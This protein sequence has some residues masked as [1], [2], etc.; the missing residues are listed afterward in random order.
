LTEV[1]GLFSGL[2]VPWWIAGGHALDLFAGRC[3]RS[4]AD[5]DVLLLR[6]DQLAAQEALRGWEWWAADPPGELRPWQP[7]ERLPESVHDIWC[8]PAVDQPWRIQVMLDESDGEDWVSRRDLRI[9]RPLGTIGH[10]AAG[11]PF[12]APEIQLFYKAKD[13]RPKDKADVA[14]ILPLLDERQRAW[15]DMTLVTFADDPDGCQ[16]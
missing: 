10:T 2:D 15:L 13:P 14:V 4:H 12:L 16:S 5:I 6:R 7:G 11:I 8:R 3:W 9:R 1:A